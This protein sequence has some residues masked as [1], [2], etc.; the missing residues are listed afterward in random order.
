MVHSVLHSIGIE[1]HEPVPKVLKENMVICIE[2]AIY[3]KKFGIRIENVILIK[4]KGCEV[5][6]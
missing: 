5:L 2:P 1:V 4:K 6:V 3:T